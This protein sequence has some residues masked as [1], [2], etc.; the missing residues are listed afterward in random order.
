MIILVA[1]FF[2]TMAVSDNWGP[3]KQQ[4]KFV[5]KWLEEFPCINEVDGDETR[6]FCT[7]CNKDLAAVNAGRVRN[8]LESK[9]YE[10]CV[11]NDN[12]IGRNPVVSHKFF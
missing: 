10:K 3:R 6:F 7:V 1:Y 4:K 8:H 12:V 5:S 11:N 2:G 9:R